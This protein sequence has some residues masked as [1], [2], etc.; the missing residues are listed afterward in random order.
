MPSRLWCSAHEDENNHESVLVHIHGTFYNPNFFT[1]VFF[2]KNILI[3]WIM[4]WL[5]ELDVEVLFLCVEVEI[6]LLVRRWNLKT[7]ECKL[8]DYQIKVVFKC[9]YSPII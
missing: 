2:W 6:G 1:N 5:R 9:E 4:I 8:N 7:D 3:L